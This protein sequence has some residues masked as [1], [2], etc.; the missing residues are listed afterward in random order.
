MTH[1]TSV[2][3]RQ[4]PIMAV[5]KSPLITWKITFDPFKFATPITYIH[6]YIKH[7]KGVNKADKKPTL[8]VTVTYNLLIFEEIPF[9]FLTMTLFRV[10]RT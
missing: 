2:I 3:A 9:Y 4:I 5:Q 8:N 6:I 10:T 7:K 1:K